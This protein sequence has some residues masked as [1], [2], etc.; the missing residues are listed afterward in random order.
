M[1][2]DQESEYGCHDDVSSLDKFLARGDGRGRLVIAKVD[3]TGDDTC[4]AGDE[5]EASTNQGVAIDAL[6]REIGR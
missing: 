1:E 6:G 2:Y 4:D 3:A 5:E